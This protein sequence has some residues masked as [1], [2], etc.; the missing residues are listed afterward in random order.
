MA[1]PS[2]LVMGGLTRFRSSF[3]MALRTWRQ[4]AGT[5]SK[6][7]FAT[8]LSLTTLYVLLAILAPLLA[9]YAPGELTGDYRQPP[10]AVHWF[11]TSKLGFDI[12]SQAVFGARI[13]IQVVLVSSVIAVLVA[14]PLGLVSGYVGS[15]WDRVL[16]LTMD[17]IY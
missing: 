14:V 13:A 11:G 6:V 10:S 4:S 7:L 9:Q 12:W 3:R 17:S 2:A 16:V 8:G 15:A 5:Q 1:P